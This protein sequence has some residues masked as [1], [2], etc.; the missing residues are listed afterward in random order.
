MNLE[1]TSKFMYMYDAI[2]FFH[3]FFSFSLRVIL[4]AEFAHLL[5]QTH[6]YNN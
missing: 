5:I 3:F 4:P 1:R 6:C 2:Y